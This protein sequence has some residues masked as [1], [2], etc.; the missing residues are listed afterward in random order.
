MIDAEVEVVINGQEIDLAREE[1]TPEQSQNFASAEL[2]TNGTNYSDNVIKELIRGTTSP[3]EFDE[4]IDNL[5]NS[6]MNPPDVDQLSEFKSIVDLAEQANHLEM[7][8]SVNDWIDDSTDQLF[9]GIDDNVLNA[10]LPFLNVGGYA[11]SYIENDEYLHITSD[12]AVISLS[13][14]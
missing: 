3:R 8:A 6:V 11:R 13:Q 4:L 14:V 5:D 7:W 1:L 2:L 12:G 9:D 10:M